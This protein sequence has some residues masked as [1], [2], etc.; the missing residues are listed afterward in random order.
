MGE[1][2]GINW[3]DHTF[4]PVRG[5]VRISAGCD[6]CYAEVM[7]K[8]NPGTLGEWGASATRVHGAESY[9]NQPAKWDKKAKGAGEIRRVFVAS[10]ADVFEGEPYPLGGAGPS[11]GNTG[12]RGDYL[13]MLDRLVET[14]APLTNLRVLVLT[15][16]PWNMLAWAKA[17][18][19][20]P[21]N[22]WAG[23]TVENQEAAYDRIQLLLQ[24]PA[25]V[26]FLSCEPLLGPV[27]LSRGWAPRV[28]GN[29]H[30]DIL[31]EQKVKELDRRDVARLD[32]SLLEASQA[33]MLGPCIRIGPA[34]CG[35]N[36]KVLM[37][38]SSSSSG[39]EWAP[40]GPT[41]MSPNYAPIEDVPRVKLAECGHQVSTDTTIHGV[42]GFDPDC[43]GCGDGN[44]MQRPGKKRAGRLLD[45]EQHDSFPSD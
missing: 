15:K 17:R 11:E 9:W 18:G 10:L 21:E 3:C 12:P 14:F 32:W 30:L 42:P 43:P 38:R 25:S 41:S 28:T 44:W 24:V 1:K 22:W 39:G 36:A 2:T 16:R 8:R 20:W 40:R 34:R 23:T 31:E 6:N 33:A 45:G 35:T 7:S 13:L 19:G 26:R 27:D 29:A 4:N 5:C 37:S